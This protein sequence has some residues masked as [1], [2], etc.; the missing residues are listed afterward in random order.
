V[1]L[2]AFEVQDVEAFFLAHGTALLCSLLVGSTSLD[3]AT[4]KIERAT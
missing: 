2:H 3:M 4:T 1:V